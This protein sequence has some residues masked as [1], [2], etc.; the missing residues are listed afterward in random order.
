MGSKE[1]RRWE[2]NPS[3]YAAGM[4]LARRLSSGDMTGFEPLFDDVKKRSAS[5]TTRSVHYISDT[6]YVVTEETETYEESH[7]SNN[8]WKGR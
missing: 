6:E 1:V 3:A 4:E 2:P 8:N 5:R 7:W